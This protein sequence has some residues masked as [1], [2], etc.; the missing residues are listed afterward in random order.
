MEVSGH[1]PA[2][3]TA[4]NN[5]PV[6]NEFEAELSPGAVRM[7]WKTGKFIFPSGTWTPGRPNP[8]L[9]TVPTELIRLILTAVLR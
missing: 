2:T 6:P 8:S 3:L 1:A 5:T 7:F 4:G 9:V